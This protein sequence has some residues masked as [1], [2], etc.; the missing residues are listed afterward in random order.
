VRAVVLAL[1]LAAGCDE[2]LPTPDF[3]STR[4]L[5]PAAPPA[6]G[7]ACDAIGEPYCAYPTEQLKCTC[8]DGAFVCASTAADLGTT[9]D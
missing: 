1:A 3:G 6:T 8:T 2:V 5:C 9:T 7:E 4:M